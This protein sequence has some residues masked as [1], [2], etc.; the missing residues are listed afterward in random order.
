[1]SINM[2]I[3]T[4]NVLNASKGGYRKKPIVNTLLT[5]WQS[6]TA[7]VRVHIFF[8]IVRK[9]RASHQMNIFVV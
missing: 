9:T 2:T 6:Y 7:S 5:H 4:I 8:D 1:M 3:S